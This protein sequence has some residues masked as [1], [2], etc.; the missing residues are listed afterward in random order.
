MERCVGNVWVKQGNSNCYDV[1]T[2]TEGDCGCSEPNYSCV[3]TSDLFVSTACQ[4]INCVGGAG[5]GGTSSDGGGGSGPVAY[6]SRESSDTQASQVYGE[7]VQDMYFYDDFTYGNSI[8][9]LYVNYTGYL[10]D[11]TGTGHASLFITD[12]VGTGN[13]YECFNRD[14][15]DSG[16]YSKFCISNPNNTYALPSGTK[17]DTQFDTSFQCYKIINYKLP[18]NGCKEVTASESL[19]FYSTREQYD[20]IRDLF[21]K[22]P[23]YLEMSQVNSNKYQIQIKKDLLK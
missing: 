11:V 3:G 21:S 16:A 14:L 23:Y 8:N 1:Q 15:F 6:M 12:C 5:G 2:N 18:N 10:A 7:V 9:P 17:V 20:N 13:N 19:Y 4:D 22:K